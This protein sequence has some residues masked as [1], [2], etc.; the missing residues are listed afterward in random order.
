MLRVFHKASSAALL[1]F[2]ASTSKNLNSRAFTT[3]V[4]LAEVAKAES[5]PVEII[6][7][8]NPNIIRW[9]SLEKVPREQ[10]KTFMATALEDKTT[11]YFT[12]SMNRSEAKVTDKE[13]LLKSANVIDMVKAYAEIV[14]P[15][16][17]LKTKWDVLELESFGLRDVIN[18]GL[19]AF[20]QS[21]ID[22]AKARL[23]VIIKE[24]SVINSQIEKIGADF[25]TISIYNNI[26]NVMRIVGQTSKNQTAIRC[27]TQMLEDMSS[28]FRISYD[29]TTK[30]LLK[31]IVFEDGPLEDSHLLFSFVEY[32]ERGEISTS[33]ATLGVIADDILKVIA[34]RHQTPLD[35]GRM[36]QLGDTHPCLQFSAE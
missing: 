33:K 26:V 30:M 32:P 22:T 21:V 23:D 16:H 17:I 3:N 4:T 20:T 1:S 36:L 12:L 24:M 10:W 6:N 14:G 35:G 18:R 31:N 9:I 28:L 34:S 7:E 11:D 27:A 25:F 2:A 29:D 8:M 5:I 13:K 15:A 19:S